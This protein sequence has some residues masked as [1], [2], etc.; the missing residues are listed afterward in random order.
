[1]RHEQHIAAQRAPAGHHL[2]FGGALDVTGN[3]HRSGAGRDAQHAAQVVAL[4]RRC[5]WGRMQ[6]LEAHAGETTEL[7][8][9][10]RQTA[11]ARVRVHVTR[12][13]KP[14]SGV[15][16]DVEGGERWLGTGTTDDTVRTPR[17]L[18]CVAPTPCAGLKHSRSAYSG[19]VPMSP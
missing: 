5:L 1:M 17:M 7:V 19:L 6:E 14:A 16:V 11:L 10:L 15:R 3:E 12:A 18:S 13:G 9:D 2:R 8:V 4:G